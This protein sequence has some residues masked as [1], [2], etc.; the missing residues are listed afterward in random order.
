MLQRPLC[1]GAALVPHSG[2]QKPPRRKT[3]KPQ[4]V[5]ARRRLPLKRHRLLLALHSAAAMA[6]PGHRHLSLSIPRPPPQS[7]P[8]RTPVCQPS[9][10]QVVTPVAMRSVNPIAKT[11]GFLLLTFRA[12]TRHERPSFD[13]KLLYFTRISPEIGSCIVMPSCA[14]LSRVVPY[15]PFLKAR[16]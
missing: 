5:P 11:A 10:T 9:R 3:P 1:A 4:A 12:E 8:P 2:Q 13:L 6:L 14:I 7:F 16:R 15:D